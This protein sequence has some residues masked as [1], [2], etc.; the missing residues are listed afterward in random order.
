MR[1]PD[2]AAASTAAWI[3]GKSPGTLKSLADTG[4][5]TSREPRIRAAAITL[6]FTFL[7]P[8]PVGLQ[9]ANDTAPLSRLQLIDVRDETRTGC[10][11]P[12]DESSEQLPMSR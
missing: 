4:T 9:A 10:T 1:S 2:A 7:T 8:E 5:A 12:Q 11:P 6:R 3:V